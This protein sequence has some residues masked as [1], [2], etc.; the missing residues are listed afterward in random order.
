ML[1]NMFTVPLWDIVL[2]VGM[3]DNMFTVS[4]WDIV[5]SGTVPDATA[6]YLSHLS[7]SCMKNGLIILENGLTDV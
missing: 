1:D 3:L 4:L 6:D 5:L 2:N 7:L